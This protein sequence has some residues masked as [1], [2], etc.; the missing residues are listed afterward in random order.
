MFNIASNSNTLINEVN[1]LM[2]NH[3][4]TVMDAV[5]YYCEKNNI[6]I[7][8]AASVIKSNPKIKSKLQIEAEDLNYL[9]KKARLPL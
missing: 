6:E 9:P 4:M 3:C 8:S 7:E 1:R 2:T 5:I